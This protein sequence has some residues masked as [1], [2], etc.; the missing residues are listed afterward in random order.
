M[1][2]LVIIPLLT[3]SL[4][5]CPLRCGLGPAIAASDSAAAGCTCCAAL[6]AVE[7]TGAA[8]ETLGASSPL[9][10]TD[11]CGCLNCICEGAVVDSDGD[12]IQM[13][14]FDF[15]DGFPIGASIDAGGV[16]RNSISPRPDGA[17]SH[18]YFLDGRAARIA[19]RSLLI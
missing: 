2:R 13:T 3:C 10:P 4:L 15:G 17:S 6:P 7:S 5:A 16:L 1:F 14:L 9:P 8:A 11:D 12:A 18:G 19:H